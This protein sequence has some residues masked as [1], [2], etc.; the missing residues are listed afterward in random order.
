MYNFYLPT[1]THTISIRSMVGEK[2]TKNFS[3]VTDKTTKEIGI[4]ISEFINEY[5]PKHLKEEI[6]FYDN[7]QNRQ[8]HI[9]VILP[10]KKE[11]SISYPLTSPS[12]SST[13]IARELQKYLCGGKH[14]F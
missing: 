1:R 5:L 13:D 7:K 11:S 2:E 6:F 14:D 9:I 3:I 8:T 4:L 10:M 12:F